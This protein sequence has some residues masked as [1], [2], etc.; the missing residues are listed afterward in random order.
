MPLIVLMQRDYDAQIGRWSA[1]DPI[2]F[3]GGDSNLYG[4]VF[5]NPINLIDPSG[6]KPACVCTAVVCSAALLPTCCIKVDTCVDD[7]GDIYH[8]H[9]LEWY[10]WGD[11]PFYI[12]GVFQCGDF[13][14]KLP[15]EPNNPYL[16][17]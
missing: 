14:G 12:L 7:D 10:I 8:E 1:K 15:G 2:L 13:P 16:E 5:N 9:S 17:F 4:Y 11:R 6:H 3:D